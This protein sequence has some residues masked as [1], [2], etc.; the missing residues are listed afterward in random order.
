M[1]DGDVKI[2]TKIDNSG[3]D[4]GLKDM[5]GKLNTASNKI[6]NNAKKLN[7]VFNEVNGSAAGFSSK[8]SGLATVSGVYT[9]AA[10]AAVA[11]VKKIGETMRET[12]EAYKT[13][14]RAEQALETAAKNNPYLNGESVAALK[15]FAGE[16][17]K[18]SNYGDEVSI[19]V[20]SQLAAAGRTEEQIMQIMA[21]AAD[22][23][24]ATGQDLASAAQQLN[25]TFNGN[26]GTLGRQISSING[27]TKA[28]LENGA[29]VEIVAAKYKG[30][31]SA[32]VD[33]QIKAKNLKG[34]YLEALGQLSKPTVD[35]WD[36]LWADFYDKGI[37][38][39]NAINALLEK[40]SRSWGIGGIKRS[41]D[42][43]VKLAA[44][45]Y[46]DN[47]GARRTGLNIQSTEYL[48]WL[49]KELEIKNSLNDSEKY[50]L[51]IINDELKYRER[52]GKEEE[53][54]AAAAKKKA[55]EEEKAAAAQQS[56]DEKAAAH[57]A[58][59]KQ[60]LNE[61]LEKIALKSKLTGEE[62][63]QQEIYNAYLNSYIDLI[64]KSSGRVSENNSAAKERLALLQQEA[65]KLKEVTDAEER[66]AKAEK[67]LNDTD[68]L[69]KGLGGT[70]TSAYK[71]F[72][73]NQQALLDAKKAL[74]AAEIKDEDLKKQKIEEIDKAM[75]QNR[76]ELWAGM[77]AEINDYASKT[78]EV[79][80]N[81]AALALETENNRMKAELANLEIKYR[82]GELSE[83]EYQDKVAAAK[84]KGAKIQYQIEMAQWASSIL[85]ATANTAVGVTQALAQGGVAG[86][87]TGA[88]V[89]AAGAV[90]L[91]SIM[92]AKPIQ[93][94]ATGGYV[95]GMNGASM[96]AD[97]TTIAARG[98]ELVVNAAQQRRL[99]EVI[100]GASGAGGGINLVV[101][102]SASN[103]VSTSAQMDRNKIELM[104]DAR[105]NDGLKRGRF[106]DGLNAAQSSMSGDFYGL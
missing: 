88:L 21:A 65:E 96:G 98:G 24:A 33:N 46:T 63:D 94:F 45:S 78:N 22:M 26:A 79:V 74:N 5:Q 91:A 43:G 100:N 6:S 8:I 97:N 2:N 52:L 85:T 32:L 70:D 72:I 1:A 44:T 34:D 101:N 13:Q 10:V 35:L 3:L 29:A 19:Q 67:L 81:A 38:R 106:N 53:K 76:R 11:A 77:S 60:A 59:N 28:E 73:Q 84:K 99:W 66:K 57:I 41:V 7:A 42:E 4:K 83:E 20:M 61:L 102:N 16:L 87:I 36:K 92:A 15:E 69:L 71:T 68:A 62:I 18:T 49:K 31:A 75:I 90:Q 51:F 14:E 89:G 58:E 93:H 82:K 64:S 50:A 80:Q 17:Q 48:E 103:I 23:A 95:G 40:I 104:I 27:L 39:V 9:A 30:M 86:I 37:K 47:E 56:A 105:V 54:Q 25:A 12:T 55:A